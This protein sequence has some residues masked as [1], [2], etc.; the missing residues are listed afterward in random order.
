M[1]DDEK[2]SPSNMPLIIYM[3]ACV[4]ITLVQMLVT[5]FRFGNAPGMSTIACN[6]VCSLICSG[7]IW[8]LITKA[9]N[10]SA[11]V[12]TVLL[13]A[14]LLTCCGLA[15]SGSGVAKYADPSTMIKIY[16]ETPSTPLPIEM[17]PLETSPVV[18]SPI[19]TSPI[20][21]LPYTTSPVVTVPQTEVPRVEVP[22]TE[23]PRA[24]V[25]PTEVPRAEVPPTNALQSN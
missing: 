1:D 23:V 10:I 24:E 2:I 20:V 18:T 11:W 14:I 15:L 21:T 17:S 19:V 5:Y 4:L 13:V 25:P 12:C 16:G 22:P 7:I 9:N 6:L 8:L 3:V